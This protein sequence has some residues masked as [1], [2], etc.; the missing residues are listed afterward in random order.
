MRII[1]KRFNFFI[2]RIVNINVVFSTPCNSI[3]YN[4][5]LR[6]RKIKTKTKNNKESIFFYRKCF[7]FLHRK[8]GQN[9]IKRDKKWITL[10]CGIDA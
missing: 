1:T 5:I 6:T 7:S 3:H 2:F 10:D 9:K 8:I 4:N